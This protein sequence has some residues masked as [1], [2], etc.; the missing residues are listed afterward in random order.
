MSRSQMRAVLSMDAVTMRLPS[1]LHV[2]DLTV[3]EPQPGQG[4]DATLRVR[5]ELQAPSELPR[6]V[7]GCF[8]AG[9][10]TEGGGGVGDQEER[11]ALGPSVAGVA[12]DLEGRVAIVAGAFEDEVRGAHGGELSVEDGAAAED[13]GVGVA[14]A[15]VAWRGDAQ[16]FV[17]VAETI[18]PRAAAAMEVGD[19]EQECRQL[20]EHVSVAH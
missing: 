2:A 20:L 19:G 14:E 18:R 15:H 5:G 6:L 4:D 10:V 13:E 17:D 3:G 8:G 12:G 11:V 7:T 16:G 1:G 9:G